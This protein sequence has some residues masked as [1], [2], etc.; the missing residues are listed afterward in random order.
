MLSWLKELLE[1]PESKIIQDLDDVASSQLHSQIIWDKKFLRNL[2]MDF[3]K[4]FRD[5]IPENDDNKLFVEIGSGGGFIKKVI[6]NVRTSDL[7]SLPAIDMKFSAL[8]MPF[9]AGSVDFF[10]LNVF[11]HITDIECFFAEVN[12]CLKLGGKIIMI[13]PANTI[14][15]RFVHS[16]FHHE[17]FDVSEGWSREENSRLASA[18]NAL[19]WIVFY[20]DRTKFQNLFPSMKIRKLKICAPFRYI[21]SGGLSYRQLLPSFTYP[22]IKFIE[23]ALYPFNRYLGM[24]LTIE[25]E[26]ENILKDEKMC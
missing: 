11:H 15:C 9:K 2:Y 13:E 22:I 12:R 24:F 3:Y 16:H 7:I 18:N 10:L 4:V 19:P 6:P 26:K 14:W 8:D 23:T 20:R 1:L 5:S 25:L 21:I 17:Y